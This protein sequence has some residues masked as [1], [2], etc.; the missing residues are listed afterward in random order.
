M[1]TIIL[2]IVVGTLFFFDFIFNDYSIYDIINMKTST[3]EITNR[4]NNRI[5]S[6]GPVAI[7]N[8]GF[9]IN[10][11]TCGDLALVNKDSKINIFEKKR[12]SLI[13]ENC[14][15]VKALSVVKTVKKDFVV[16]VKLDTP[17]YWSSD[18][19]LFTVD[20]S[21]WDDFKIKYKDLSLNDLKRKGVISIDIL[22]KNKIVIKNNITN[23]S[24]LAQEVIRGNFDKD[25][26]VE[27]LIEIAISDKTDTYVDDYKV[28]IFSKKTRKEALIKLINI[29]D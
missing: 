12:L 22:D 2:I 14:K 1:K 9:K 20:E 21:G 17:K 3:M 4:F 24:M 23:R 25:D 29:V 6:L 19:A 18:L 13:S 16:H 11:R 8:K 27:I 15:V 5:K 28:A 7:Y 10:I 26:Y